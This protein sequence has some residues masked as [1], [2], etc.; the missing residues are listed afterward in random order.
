MK[1]D[2]IPKKDFEHE[3]KGKYPIGS[4]ISRREQVGKDFTQKEVRA[5]SW[6]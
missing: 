4:P 3:L 6:G 2:R 5:H 1:E